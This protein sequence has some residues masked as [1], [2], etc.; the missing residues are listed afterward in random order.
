MVTRSLVP[1]SSS[2]SPVNPRFH[3][4]PLTHEQQQQL[5]VLAQTLQGRLV[6]SPGDF[7]QLSAFSFFPFAGDLWSEIWADNDKMQHWCWGLGQPELPLWLHQT[8]KSI[9]SWTF[10]STWAPNPQNPSCISKHQQHLPCW[11]WDGACPEEQ[12]RAVGFMVHLLLSGSLGLAI[13][14]A[15]G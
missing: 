5:H 15:V 4:K 7:S 8:P 14:M 11:S 9:T 6:P 10:P 12:S 1:L 2:D 3:H 13:S